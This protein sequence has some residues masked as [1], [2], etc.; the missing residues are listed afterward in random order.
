MSMK[1]NKYISLFLIL[2]SALFLQGYEPDLDDFLNPYQFKLHNSWLEKA[3]LKADSPADFTTSKIIQHFIIGGSEIITEYDW[4]NYKIYN[5]REI[6][7]SSRFSLPPEI[8]RFLESF[9][10]RLNAA[11][12]SFI[13]NFLKD[14]GSDL[15]YTDDKN[16]GSLELLWSKIGAERV[17]GFEIVDI[18]LDKAENSIRVFSP[19]WQIEL[20]FSDPNLSLAHLIREESQRQVELIEDKKEVVGITV[21]IPQT[22]SLEEYISRNYQ[23]KQTREMLHNKIDDVK[24]FLKKEFP[25]HIITKTTKGYLISSENFQGEFPDY[26]KIT[27]STEQ[28]GVYIYSDNDTEI[29]GKTCKISDEEIIDLSKL[30]YQEINTVSNYLPQLLYEH[31]SIGSKLLDFLLIHD[32]VPTTLLV[33]TETRN[34]YE[35]ASYADLLLMLNKY[36]LDRKIYFKLEDFKKINNYIEFKGFLLAVEADGINADSA[37]IWFHLD[38]SLKIDLIMMMLY[39]EIK[40]KEE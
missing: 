36:W 29:V 32:N 22:L 18:K 21:K 27:Y 17:S 20:I 28:D 25:E 16:E 4:E 3:E 26:L 5:Q 38:K 7:P 35:I 10:Y 33:K 19:D 23:K 40:L 24:S 37:E 9:L 2:I 39:P 8:L 12:S 6:L 11:D 1:M 15:L 13:S 30:S 31:R 34:K 14:T